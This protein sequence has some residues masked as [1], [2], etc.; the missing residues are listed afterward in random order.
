MHSV[1]STWA[2]SRNRLR[3]HE[4]STCARSDIRQ[5]ASV[6]PTD[7]ANPPVITT[8]D[9]YTD[10]RRESRYLAFG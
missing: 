10:A 2:S 9:G 3:A 7:A 5:T 6:A 4:L 8:L 1:L